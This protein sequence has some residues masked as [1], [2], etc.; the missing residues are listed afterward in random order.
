MNKDNISK[1]YDFINMCNSIIKYYSNEDKHYSIMLFYVKDKLH[2]RIINDEN[3]IIKHNCDLECNKENSDLIINSITS[4]FILNHD[5]KYVFSEPMQKNDIFL[6]RTL[7]GDTSNIVI[8]SNSYL[9]NG[10]NMEIHTFENTKFSLKIFLYNGID[11]QIE[12]LHEKVKK[13]SIH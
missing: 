9:N 12:L 3:G 13:K 4:E 8:T 5:L 11:T 2:F 7:G 1:F 10:K 6:Y